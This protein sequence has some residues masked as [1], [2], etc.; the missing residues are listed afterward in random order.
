MLHLVTWDKIHHSD[1]VGALSRWLLAALHPCGGKLLTWQQHT[2][3][4]TARFTHY[5]CEEIESPG[6]KK[7]DIIIRICW[8]RF[9]IDWKAF[10]STNCRTTWRTRAVAVIHSMSCQCGTLR[11]TCNTERVMSLWYYTYDLLYRARDAIV[12]LYVWPV[13][14]SMSCH[15]GT[16][17]MTC[18]T[19]RVMSLWYYTYDL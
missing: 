15:C 1:V 10:H 7:N 2:I 3:I 11:M 14:H 19:E 6:V 18:N 17:R 5:T 13:I 12:V 9:I 4:Q 8:F 16:L